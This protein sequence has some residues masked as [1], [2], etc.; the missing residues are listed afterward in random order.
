MAWITK[1]S[2]GA[3]VDRSAGPY[4]TDGMKTKLRETYLPRYETALAALM[5]ALHMIQHEHGWVPHAAMLEIAEELSLPP[6]D[7]F[8][9]ATFYEEYWLKPAGKR[10]VSVCRSIACE[11]CGQ[12]HIT[13]AIRDRLGIE[14]G[15]TTQD[16][17]FSLVELECIG[18]C[19]TAPAALVGERLHENLTPQ[20]MLEILDEVSKELDQAHGGGH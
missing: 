6:A 17:K 2:A 20:R 12:Q 19:G 9:T 18:S 8:D 15:E 10:V 14:V 13:D 16:G 11:F 4:L 5:P 7:V 3:K 1:D